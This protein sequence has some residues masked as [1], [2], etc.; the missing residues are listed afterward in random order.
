MLGEMATKRAAAVLAA[1]AIAFGGGL[2][3]CGEDD[4]NDAA[5]DVEDELN[6]DG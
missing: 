6:G 1:G 4:V 3:G 2:A 5:G